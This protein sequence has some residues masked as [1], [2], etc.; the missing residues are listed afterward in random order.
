MAILSI[1]TTQSRCLLS[2]YSLAM[3]PQS[4][5]LVELKFSGDVPSCV[6]DHMR[7]FCV[8]GASTICYAPYG[9]DSSVLLPADDCRNWLASMTK[10]IRP[11]WLRKKCLMW[12]TKKFRRSSLRS[13]CHKHH[14]C[15]SMVDK[16]VGSDGTWLRAQPLALVCTIVQHHGSPAGSGKYSAALMMP[17]LVGRPEDAV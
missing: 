16:P 12:R 8:P 14:T 10:D 1:A 3:I 17:R 15:T 11:T 9:T 2:N 6:D 5:C 4:R 7:C 13:P